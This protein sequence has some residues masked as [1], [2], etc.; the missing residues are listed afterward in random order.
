MLTNPLRDVPNV[1]LA[2]VTPT[3]NRPREVAKILAS[4]HNQARQPDLVVIVDGSDPELRPEVRRIVKQDWPGAHYL[5]HW[6]PSAAAQRNHGLEAVLAKDVDLIAF[7]DD[8]VT[9]PADAL[10]VASREILQAVPEFIGFGLNPSDPD[11]NRSY[12]RMKNS[13]I[14]RR[15]GLYSDRVSAVTVSG[16]HTRLLQVKSPTEVDWLP[17]GASIWKARAIRNVRFDEYFEEYS[18]LEDLEFSLCARE[19]G[20]LLLLS[21]AY[22]LHEP[23]AGGR[24][25]RFWFGRIEIRNRLYI[26]RKHGLSEPRFWLGAVVRATLTLGSVLVGHFEEFGRLLGNCAEVLRSCAIS[27]KMRGSR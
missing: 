14:A 6:P 21:S 27:K 2:V 20:R 13:Q 12:G 26:V 11:S 1:R 10:E 9:L 5:E 3:R 23:A 15:L 19:Q 7:I 4:L 17:S 18:Y 22:F 25:S 24:K 16:W 8:D